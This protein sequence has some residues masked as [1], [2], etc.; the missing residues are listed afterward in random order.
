MLSSWNKLNRLLVPRDRVRLA[1]LL[2]PMIL[3]ALANVFGIALIMPF[4]SV[5]ADPGMIQT[6]QKLFWLYHAFGFHSV[7]QFVVL[8][9]VAA[10]SML[11]LTNGL[12]AFTTWL[13]ARVV[14]NVRSRITQN[15]Y[16][17]YLDQPYEFFLNHNSSTLVNNLFQL[18]SQL[19]QGFILQGMTFCTNLISVVAIITLVLIVNP[20]M[21][22]VTAG[23]M[24]GVFGVLFF[25]TKKILA[26]GGA[27]MVSESE[28]ALKLAQES[29]GGIKDLKLRG[30]EALFKSMMYPKLKAMSDFSALQQMLISMPRYGLEVIAFGGVLG[31]VLSMLIA[32]QSVG[33]ILPM[34]AVYVYSGYRLMPAMQSLFSSLGSI[35]SARSALD[36]IHE[37]VTNSQAVDHQQAPARPITFKNQLSLQGLSYHYP[38]YERLVLKDLNLNIHHHEIVGIIGHTGAGKTTLIDI[39][40]GL[41]QPTSG[42]LAVDGLQLA[43]KTTRSAWQ[44]MIGYVPQHI[45]LSDSSIAHNIA[46]GVDPEAIDLKVVERVAKIAAIHDFIAE[47]LPNG[48][49]TMVGERGVKLSGGQIQRIGIARALYHQPKVLILDEATSSLDHQTESDVMRAIYNMR[50]KMTMV[51]IA[52]RL[53]TVAC[54]DRVVLLNEGQV[55]DEGDLESLRHRHA[56]LSNRLQNT[57]SVALL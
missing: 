27:V 5:V 46:F 31:I 47:Q 44:S 24:G 3:T 50:N 12:A 14:S 29:F 4:L 10:L 36:R 8:L 43:C 17:H 15:I 28:S 57:S 34:V 35:E 37:S 42:H 7:H 55:I 32:K 21:A 38:G 30:N 49:H 6:N 45:Y 52:H 2:I 19:T 41:L 11:V 23:L 33:T 54:C 9:G 22:F 53:S 56:G 16:T 39:L 51:I 20:M 25:S 13:S 48:Y 18:S 40:L 1:W 26:R